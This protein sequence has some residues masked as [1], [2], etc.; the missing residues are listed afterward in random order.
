MDAQTSARVRRRIASCE[1]RNRALLFV[2]RRSGPRRILPLLRIHGHESFR[3]LRDQGDPA[4]VVFWHLGVARAVELMLTRLG[5]SVLGASLEESPRPLPGYRA[6]TVSDASSGTRF[7]MEA[8]RELKDGGVPVLAADGPGR[9]SRRTRFL[10]RQLPLP[11]GIARLARM[12]SARVVPATSRWIGTSSAIEVTLHPPL[13]EPDASHAPPD[14]E[15]ELATQVMRWFES[16]LRSH[17]EDLRPFNIRRC[18]HP[19]TAPEETR[20]WQGC[21]PSSSQA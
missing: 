19:A 1:V 11:S 4:V 8:L 3:Q 14:W 7:L 10:G 6:L 16:H 18:L 12:A 9:G 17:P 13:P 5:Y 21:H 2:L 15:D 20:T